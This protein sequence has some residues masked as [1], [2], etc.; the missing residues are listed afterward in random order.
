MAQDS[1]DTLRT[2][3]KVLNEI[4]W[5]GRCN[6]PEVKRWLA[7]FGGGVL[8]DPDVERLHALHLLSHLS[9][10]GIREIREL[11]KAMYR[12]LFRYPIVQEIRA[13]N[14]WTRDAVVI[15]RLFEQEVLATRF[16]G[17][18]NPA[19]SG[20]HLLYYFRQVNRLPKDLFVSENRLLTESA[21]SGNALFN[22]GNLRHVVFIDDFCG[23]G[24]QSVQY[25]RGILSDL[26][27]V[28]QQTGQAIDLMY[29]VLFGASAGLAHARAHSSFDTIAAVHEFDNSFKVFCPDSRIFRKCPP[30]VSQQQSEEMARAYGLQLEPAQ[31]LG[32]LDGQLLLAFHHN[33]PDNSLP[34]LWSDNPQLPWESILR[35]EPKV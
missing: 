35:R 1:E 9:Y 22:P 32:Y 16:V 21:R 15:E 17:M 14:G 7:N 30:G 3:I 34:I 25:S 5:E 13:A 33:I 12:D 18:G 11:L 2:K 4:I 29:L 10:F 8:N 27:H 28:A 23:S 20:T 24:T 31:P 6:A 19:E 26:Q